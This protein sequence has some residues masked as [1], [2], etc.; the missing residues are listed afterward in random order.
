L[1]KLGNMRQ[2][3]SDFWKGKRVFITGHTGF[4]GSWLSIWL[5][6]LG[7]ELLGVSLD[8]PT[9]PSLFIE[10]DVA[11]NMTSKIFSIT[12]FKKLYQT[13]K[14]FN[15]E[16]V[17]H[18]AAQPLVRQSYINPLETYHT[19]LLGTVHVL[20]A[21]RKIKAVK[22]ILNVTSDKCYENKEWYWGY[23][24]SDPMGGEDPYSSSKG[25]SEIIT[26]SYYKSFFKHIEVGLASARAGNV[27]GGGD[28]SQDRLI[29]D[30]LRS[31]NGREDLVIRNPKSTRPWQHVLEPLHGYLL[32]I[33]SLYTS[34]C[35]FSGGWNFGPFDQSVK[36][37]EWIVN[38]LCEKTSRKNAWYLEQELQPH[39]AKFLKLDI[40][41]SQIELG[42]QPKLDIGEALEK[43]IEWN[44]SWLN[45]ENVKE[46][47]LQQIRAFQANH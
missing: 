1:E 14:L 32:L 40:S 28:W 31:I 35:E 26:N 7:V 4:K 24:E 13:M 39:E 37:V 2:L 34:P 12:D 46:K 22:A 8:P 38:F 43:V 11:K 21:A 5:Q 23:R 41:K 44:H 17:L 36:T 10:A 9:N 33:E 27:I 29:P 20:E 42:W 25:C 45:K 19:N 6:S 3:N 47:C 30:I 16:I 15:P 18:L